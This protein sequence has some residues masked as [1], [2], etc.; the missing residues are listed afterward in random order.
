MLNNDVLVE[1]LKMP[2]YCHTGV[3]RHPVFL[4]RQLFLDP[5]ACPGHRS[6]VHRDDDFLRLHQ[7]ILVCTILPEVCPESPGL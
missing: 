1:R 6:G 2:F 5:G 7:I 3:S 4:S